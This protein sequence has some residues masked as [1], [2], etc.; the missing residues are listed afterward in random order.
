MIINIMVCF[1]C[2]NSIFWYFNKKIE[3]SHNRRPTIFS[4]P[5]SP[6]T[7]NERIIDGSKK[8]ILQNNL[9]RNRFTTA[10]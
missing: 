5:S 7:N 9:D 2:D 1:L 8:K 10:F 3:L 6:R 4:K